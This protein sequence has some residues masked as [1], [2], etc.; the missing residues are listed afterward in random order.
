MNHRDFRKVPSELD[1]H[2]MICCINRAAPKSFNGIQ[3]GEIVISAK[4][5]V[6]V[7]KHFIKKL[8]TIK[9]S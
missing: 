2:G 5:R 8:L 6:T 9:E 3:N 4:T 7:K 1:S